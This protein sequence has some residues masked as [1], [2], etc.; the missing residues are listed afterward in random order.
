MSQNNFRVANLANLFWDNG[1]FKYP[2]TYPKL[3]DG[4][5][6]NKTPVMTSPTTGWVI[7]VGDWNYC[8][9]NDDLF[10]LRKDKVISH[11]RNKW[12]YVLIKDH[13]CS[14]FKNKANVIAK[15]TVINTDLKHLKPND[16][17]FTFP[18]FNNYNKRTLIPLK[19]DPF[20]WRIHSEIYKIPKD[21]R[22]DSYF[23]LTDKTYSNLVGRLEKLRD[24]FLKDPV[25]S[26]NEIVKDNKYLCIF[27]ILERE[28][29]KISSWKNELIDRI[30]ELL[31]EAQNP[32]RDDI[33]LGK[34]INATIKGATRLT[35]KWAITNINYSQLINVSDNNT[36]DV[37]I[38]LRGLK[39]I[40]LINFENLPTNQ[41]YAKDFFSIYLSYDSNKVDEEIW[42][43]ESHYIHKLS[44]RVRLPFTNKNTTRAV[45]QRNQKYYNWCWDYNPSDSHLYYPQK[46]FFKLTE[47]ET[48]QPLDKYLSYP[49]KRKKETY[50]S[51]Y[52]YWCWNL[53]FYF[54]WGRSLKFNQ[55][56]Y[57]DNSPSSH[58]WMN[59]EE[60]WPKEDKYNILK[61]LAGDYYQSSNTEQSLQLVP[62]KL[63][64]DTYEA[65]YP[66]KK[67]GGMYVGEP[68]NIGWLLGQFSTHLPYQSYYFE[69][70]FPYIIKAGVAGNTA[71]YRLKG[72]N[73]SVKDLIQLQDLYKNARTGSDFTLEIF[74]RFPHKTRES[75]LE[76]DFLIGEKLLFT[77]WGMAPYLL[78][79]PAMFTY[80]RGSPLDWSLT[81][82]TLGIGGIA[83]EGYGYYWWTSI[84]NYYDPQLFG[85][86]IEYASWHYPYVVFDQGSYF[87]E[88]AKQWF[89]KAYENYQPLE[90]DRF[91]LNSKNYKKLKLHVQKNTQS[92]FVTEPVYFKDNPIKELL[93]G[94]VFFSDLEWFW[95]SQSE[96][97]TGEGKRLKA[98]T[99]SEFLFPN[100]SL[101]GDKELIN[102]D[103][104]VY[105]HPKNKKIYVGRVHKWNSK[106]KLPSNQYIAKVNEVITDTMAEENRFIDIKYTR[107]TPMEVD[108]S[109]KLSGFD[110]LDELISILKG[111]RK[112]LREPNNL[113][114]LQELQRPWLFNL[115]GTPFLC[116]LDRL[117]RVSLIFKN[118]E[119]YEATEYWED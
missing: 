16:F 78:F 57:S 102:N 71:L 20:D 26:W 119:E 82:F 112:I 35:G 85:K 21:V 92:F 2:N 43:T 6:V 46:V 66:W 53:N 42:S 29:T 65:E 93:I 34:I 98:P 86:W 32:L 59:A 45:C 4:Q 62:S 22:F 64:T 104:V 50:R 83:Y 79:Q 67:G 109:K 70:E 106:M 103:I 17:Q 7:L 89:K 58:T 39:D 114:E 69:T 27:G 41:L 31:D 18:V 12:V 60:L 113:Q 36:R 116:L 38:D 44:R 77:T 75:S 54:V 24:Y 11:K 30:N 13:I 19:E 100:F 68:I 51:V 61:T 8:Q 25:Q 101:Q 118:K 96:A 91:Y 14:M 88:S 76:E 81:P 73:E 108:Q 111:N 97:L 49:T 80:D 99:A 56:S 87:K 94:D 48:L 40:E 105:L 33:H 95:F 23:P 90:Y 84:D 9:F 28:K 47:D 10:F 1:S 74:N 117:G 107:I 37:T 15:G 3:I 5:F 115:K 52:L 72:L 55:L 63:E 110:S